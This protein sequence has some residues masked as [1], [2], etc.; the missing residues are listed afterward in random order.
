MTV[1]AQLDE[2]LAAWR[3]RA[4]EP[5]EARDAPAPDVPVGRV[6]K[7]TVSVKRLS[8]RW[9][10]AE[11]RAYPASINA[12]RPRPATR[13][14]CLQ[15]EHAERPCPFVSCRRHLAYDVNPRSGAITENHPGRELDELP[16][17]CTLDAADRGGL[18]LEEV[19]AALNLTRER[20]RQLE[21]RALA[22]LRRLGIVLAEH[23][24]EP[25]DD[26]DDGAPRPVA[27]DLDD[28]DDGAFDAIDFTTRAADDAAPGDDDF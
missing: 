5:A 10:E 28:G 16:Y 25:P 26:L 12:A 14:E 22:K 7:R 20:V 8:K 19:G 18:T 4:R 17:T 2:L 13:G 15:G 21:N 24:D 9:L 6:R 23:L 1:A 27:V 3:D 11:A